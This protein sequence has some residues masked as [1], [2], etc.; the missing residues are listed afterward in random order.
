MNTLSYWDSILISK[1]GVNMIICFEYLNCTIL[2]LVKVID[3]ESSCPY[4]MELQWFNQAVTKRWFTVTSASWLYIT[5][6]AHSHNKLLT[7]KLLVPSSIPQLSF[8]V[9]LNNSVCK[10]FL[11]I[12]YYLL[13]EMITSKHN[14]PGSSNKQYILNI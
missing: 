2:N 10:T 13:L 3:A 8:H 5:H 9:Y 7:I 12:L 6:H 4:N 14:F 1:S 11:Y